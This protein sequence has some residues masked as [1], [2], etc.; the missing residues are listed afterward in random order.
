MDSH[1]FDTRNMFSM[2]VHNDISMGSKPHSDQWTTSCIRRD[3][4]AA[5]WSMD[6][7]VSSNNYHFGDLWILGWNFTEEMDGKTHT[8]RLELE[9]KAWNELP[10]RRLQLAVL[11]VTAAAE[12]PPRQPAT[13]AEAH[14]RTMQRNVGGL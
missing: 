12:H 7:V 3:S 11:A 9:A 10:N 5:F 2:V 14:V 4:S 6:K 1:C 13:A 8:F